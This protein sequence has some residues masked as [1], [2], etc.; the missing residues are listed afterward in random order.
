[1]T[2]G[3]IHWHQFRTFRMLTDVNRT[4]ISYP[5]HSISA[6]S[7]NRDQ[8]AVD[9][10]SDSLPGPARPTD[11][12]PSQTDPQA[13]T[14]VDQIFPPIEGLALADQDRHGSFHSISPPDGQDIIPE[15]TPELGNS[16]TGRKVS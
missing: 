16:K 5:Q 11:F 10:L 3:R 9:V 7:S 6:T 1:M 8:T 12:R 14:M 4:V 2:Y 15:E 13:E